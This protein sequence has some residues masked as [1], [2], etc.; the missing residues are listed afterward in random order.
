MP[1]ISYVIHKERKVIHELEHYTSW[2]RV[3]YVDDNITS[4]IEICHNDNDAYKVLE[5]TKPSEGYR[6]TLTR[7]TKD[8]HGETKEIMRIKQ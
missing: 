2:D 1:T 7:V 5:A 4:A 6:F 3:P 8:K